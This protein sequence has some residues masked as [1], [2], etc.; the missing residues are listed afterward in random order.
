MMIATENRQTPALDCSNLNPKLTE[1]RGSN[2]AGFSQE[3]NS[4]RYEHP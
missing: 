2:V 1:A 3:A 4:S